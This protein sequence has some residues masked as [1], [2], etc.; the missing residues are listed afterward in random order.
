[1][2]GHLFSHEIGKTSSVFGRKHDINVVFQG[3]GAATDGSTIILPTLD[4][5]ADVSDQQQDIMRGY[6]DHESGHVRH[7]DFDALKKFAV[8][9]GGNKLLRSV[10]NALEDVWLERRVIDEY[11]AQPRTSRPCPRQ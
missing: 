11:P 6:V 3:D 9:C 2:K 4:H 5:N 7:T 10:H 1:M 8:E